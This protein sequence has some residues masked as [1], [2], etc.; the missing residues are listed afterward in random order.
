MLAYNVVLL[1]VLTLNAYAAVN[2][3]TERVHAKTPYKWLNGATPGRP[4]P[5]VV[6]AVL[7]EQ[8]GR[9][10]L[11][12]DLGWQ[13]DEALMSPA[14]IGLTVPWTVAGSLRVL[15]MVAEAGAVER[16]LFL[17]LLGAA[18]TSPAHEWLIAQ[19]VDDVSK[20]EGSAI[21]IEVVDDLD[22]IASHLR[23]MDD[24]LGG[25]SLL[26]LVKAQLTYVTGLIE[27]R[28]Y[29]ETVGRRLHAS[30]AELLRLAGWLSFDSGRHGPAQRFWISALHAAH[31][32]G[33]RA[34][35]A[36]ILGFMS[37]QAKDLGHI[38]EAVT[39]AET[40]R[41]GYPG[42]SPQVAAILDLRAAEAYA[43]EQATTPC[44]RAIDD[45]FGHL[46]SAPDA[47]STPAWS[48]WLDQT[49]AHGQAGYCYLVL[50]DWERARA[51]LR[52]AVRSQISER[53]REAAL[54][55]ALLATTYARQDQPVIEQA[56]AYGT[57]AVTALE[58][59]VNS[60]RCVGHVGRLTESL[61][62]F[63]RQHLVR[64]FLER[65]RPLVTSAAR[66]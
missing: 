43:N 5:T 41:T 52:A 1:A 42:A 61:R 48:Y 11:P 10:V 13:A 47:P 59:E 50:H 19:Q 45:A 7:T 25:G 9:P 27:H 15:H 56:V 20:L 66:T 21:P 49:H 18:A 57:K 31:A 2:G 46:D 60:P 26:N 8:L 22:K 24:A 55:H 40:A 54:R 64:D 12:A 38:R 3:I 4:W 16:R 63:H 39:L 58:S 37:C 14:S 30:A 53:S 34:L 33:D 23:N 36:N 65:S 6:A 62:P 51:H 44:R 29:D 32:A 28:S 17:V 35:G